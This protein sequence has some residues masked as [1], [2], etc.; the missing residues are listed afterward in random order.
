MNPIAV[1]FIQDLSAITD[2]NNLIALATGVAIGRRLNL[3][4][5]Y[6]E[7]KSEE[8][9]NTLIQNARDYVSKVNELKVIDTTLALDTAKAT[10]IV[11]FNAMYPTTIVASGDE[12]IWCD[13]F[14]ISSAFRDIDSTSANQNKDTFIK[15]VSLITAIIN[16]D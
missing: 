7:G 14:S 11:R 5:D 9:N 13:T 16:S 6:L 1:S 10:Y 4:N 8:F 12:C 2:D 15:A 3:P